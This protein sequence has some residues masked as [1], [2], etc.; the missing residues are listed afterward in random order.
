MGMI[1]KGVVWTDHALS[2]MKERGIPIDH[3]L[4]TLNSPQE[5]RRGSDKDAWVYYRTWG[6]DRIEVVSKQNEKREWVV[7]SVWSKKVENVKGPEPWWEY[8]LRQILG[9]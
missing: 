7:L 8:L 2:R 4:V 3:A 1:Y 5:S 6:N 9:R